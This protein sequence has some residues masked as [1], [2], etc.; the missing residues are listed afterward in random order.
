MK[1]I[2][3]SAFLLCACVGA[4]SAQKKAVQAEKTI[5]YKTQDELVTREELSAI[6]KD[7]LARGKN[8]QEVAK[9]MDEEYQKLLAKKQADIINAQAPQIAPTAEIAE[10][11]QLENKKM[12]SK[13]ELKGN[14]AKIAIMRAEYEKKRTEISNDL[15]KKRFSS[16]VEKQNLVK[17]EEEKLKNQYPMLFSE[18]N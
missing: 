12:L 2:F 3:L 13:E 4:V 5:T 15:N 11:K 14:E 7:A 18:K 9:I 8:Q 16:N 10:R 1:K 6:K 17:Q